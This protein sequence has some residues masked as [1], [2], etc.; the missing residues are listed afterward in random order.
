[1]ER[2]VNDLI[3][4]RKDAKLSQRQLGR[5]SGIGYAKV[6][7]IETRTRDLWVHDMDAWLRACNSSIA[8]Y[9]SREEMLAELK[10]AHED[11]HL[12]RLFQRALKIPG[13]RRPVKAVLESVFSSD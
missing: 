6:N 5:K 9:F 10:V 11:K 4:L 8:E 2:I 13:K 1:M 3:E 7:A 12:A